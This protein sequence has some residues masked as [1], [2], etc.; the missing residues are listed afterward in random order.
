MRIVVDL[1]LSQCDGPLKQLSDF[2]PFWI[3][4]I[5]ATA[6]EFETP[7]L[8]RC[9]AATPHPQGLTT[10]PGHH[11]LMG[12]S[13]SRTPTMFPISNLVEI[14]FQPLVTLQ[15]HFFHP[16][17]R[18]SNIILSKSLGFYKS[19]ENPLT[20]GN[21]CIL[22]CKEKKKNLRQGIVK[23]QFMGLKQEEIQ[24][25]REPHKLRSQTGVFQSACTL[26]NYVKH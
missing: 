16:P 9:Y 12:H 18:T 26:S 14:N 7:A 20:S 5:F 23:N 3:K 11:Q 13:N 1:L 22:P 24:I 21:V 19:P 10:I 15:S 4:R 8:Q 17:S 25:Q 6:R 2:L